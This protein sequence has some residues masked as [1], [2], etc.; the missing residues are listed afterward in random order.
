MIR[1]PS[2]QLSDLSLTRYLLKDM[3]LVGLI[4]FS[5]SISLASLFARR[6]NYKIDPTQELYA[7][8]LSNVFGSMFSCF[9]STGSLSRSSLLETT[10]AK[11]QVILEHTV[12]L[13]YSGFFF[14][15]FF[16]DYLSLHQCLA[17]QL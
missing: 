17:L 4:S 16:F 10:G 15:K 12:I 1:L 5:I 8:G 9:P 7:L 14:S 11:S 6:K 13:I 3:F 2:P